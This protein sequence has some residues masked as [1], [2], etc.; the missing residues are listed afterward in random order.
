MEK[1][2]PEAPSVLRCRIELDTDLRDRV[3]SMSRT[4]SSTAPKLVRSPMAGLPA[5]LVAIKLG[6]RQRSIR[7]RRWII[8][9]RDRGER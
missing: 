7:L 2:E 4:I 5:N 1:L 3:P 9:M 6:E 8:Q